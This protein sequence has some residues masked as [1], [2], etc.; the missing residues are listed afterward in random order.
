[1]IKYPF[2]RVKTSW[3]FFQAHVKS[4]IIRG[5][6]RFRNFTLTKIDLALSSL[7]LDSWKKV[8]DRM[9]NK[10]DNWMI[11]PKKRIFQEAN[12]KTISNFSFCLHFSSFIEIGTLTTFEP[13]NLL[14][15][16]LNR[17]QTMSKHL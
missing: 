9:K 12:C 6:I 11:E 17:H 1:M 15:I 3:D 2:A 10:Q 5:L 16:S 8:V 14:C 7:N 4:S 13:N